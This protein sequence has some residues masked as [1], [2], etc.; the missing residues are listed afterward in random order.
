MDH[1]NR[2]SFTARDRSSVKICVCRKCEAR[3]EPLEFQSLL[4]CSH[5]QPPSMM[6]PVC[7]HG[8]SLHMPC[9]SCKRKY[10]SALLRDIPRVQAKRGPK[11]ANKLDPNA[12]PKRITMTRMK[13]P[14]MPPPE[15][16][17]KRSA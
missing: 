11:A 9:D 15:A 4:Y 7:M 1:N 10:G 13:P 16:S 6:Q 14:T 17:S 8:V 2:L 3:Y 12:R 5:C